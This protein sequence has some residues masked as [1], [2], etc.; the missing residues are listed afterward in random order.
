MKKVEVLESIRYY[1]IDSFLNESIPA[2]NSFENIEDLGFVQ[3][4]DW[5]LTKSYLT[6]N[7]RFTLGLRRI[8]QN[9]EKVRFDVNQLENAF[10]VFVKPSGIYTGRKDILIAGKIATISDTQISTA[11][12]TVFQKQIRKEFEKVGAFWV[13]PTAF[14][15]LKDGW[16]FTTSTEA[17]REYDLAL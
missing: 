4:G 15:Y 2:Y 5:N 14:Q 13:G 10:S 12:Y 9:D 3:E 16:R 7:P 11:L 17:P 1:L 6:Q 8:L